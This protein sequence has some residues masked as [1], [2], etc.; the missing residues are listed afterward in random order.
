MRQSVPREALTR[1]PLYHQPK[2][3]LRL[4][5]PRLLPDKPTFLKASLPHPS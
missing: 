5:R 2:K 3:K 1:P 4:R